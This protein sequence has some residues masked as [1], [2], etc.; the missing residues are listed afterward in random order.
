MDVDKVDKLNQS[1]FEAGACLSNDGQTLRIEKDSDVFN[2]FSRNDA[3]YVDML[4]LPFYRC[5]FHW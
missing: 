2:G 5:C 4:P 3:A 1:N